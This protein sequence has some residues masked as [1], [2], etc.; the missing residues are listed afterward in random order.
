MEEKI[1]CPFCGSESIAEILYGMPAF[2]EELDR[3][4]E[5]KKII[6]GGCIISEDSPEFHCNKCHREWG[7]HMKFRNEP[8]E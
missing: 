7:M 2:S 5:Q 6:L 1:K 8:G 3:E 4:L